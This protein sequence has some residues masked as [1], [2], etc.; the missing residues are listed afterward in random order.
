MRLRDVAL[1]LAAIAGCLCALLAWREEAG[2]RIPVESAIRRFELHERRPA[3]VGALR[4]QP[5]ADLRAAFFSHMTLLDVYSPVS[6]K[7]MSGEERR[8]WIRSLSSVDEQ[9]SAALKLELDAL[10]RR[11]GWAFHHAYAGEVAWAALRRDS[12][13]AAA[14]WTARWE[15]PLLNGIDAAPGNSSFASFLAGAYIET[16]GGAKPSG[17]TTA[18]FRSAMRSRAFVARN[19]GVVAT[20]VG[21]EEAMSLLPDD[22]GTLR[23]ALAREKR[24]GDVATV[25]A[26]RLRVD[27]S[28]RRARAASLERIRERKRLGDTWG[29]RAE[30]LRWVSAHQLEDL[31][32]ATGRAQSAEVLALWPE[33]HRGSW[34]KDPRG[35][36]VRYFLS[37]RE[38]AVDGSVLLATTSLLEDVPPPVAARVAALAGRTWDAEQ[39]MRS[40]GTK[41][42]FEWT[43][44]VVELARAHAANGRPDLAA[45]VVDMA[46]GASLDECNMLLARREIEKGDA[47]VE[48]RLRG[49]TPRTIPGEAW[50]A[51][52]ALPLCVDP[53]RHGDSKVVVT[54]ESPGVSLVSWGWDGGRVGSLLVE[55]RGELSVALS[56]IEG[57]HPLGIVTEA[58]PKVRI[59]GARIE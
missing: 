59:A 50:S 6:L 2:A 14:A 56:G 17:D 15:T 8:R 47:R 26:L 1:L 49:L 53:R 41:G 30:A 36:I 16:W 3:D 42:S 31:D 20:I 38:R 5:A 45:A 25:A 29:R 12:L 46:P 58:G 27:E 34:L 40:S 32:D 13:D 48:E 22:P 39:L 44:V 43:P 24:D 11:P 54:L 7:G 37:G 51:T 18:V 19:Y 23:V 9:L 57:R 33:S 21:R 28:E 55:G 10:S 35:E 4:L 52:G